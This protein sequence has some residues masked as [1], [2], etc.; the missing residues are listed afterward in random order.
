MSN[1]SIVQKVE[2]LNYLFSYIFLFYNLCKLRMVLVSL[3]YSKIIV[4]S[5]L[6]YVTFI[7]PLIYVSRMLKKLILFSTLPIQYSIFSLQFY[8]LPSHIFYLHNNLKLINYK[9]NNLVRNTSHEY[10]IYS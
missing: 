6:R 2:D 3:S 1:M 7:D 8:S 10:I 9:I 4:H 5:N